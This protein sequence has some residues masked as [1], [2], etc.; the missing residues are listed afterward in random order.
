[1]RCYTINREADSGQDRG[2]LRGRKVGEKSNAS[3]G[4]RRRE[5]DKGKVG[6]GRTERWGK[7]RGG[8]VSGRAAVMTQNSRMLQ[9]CLSSNFGV[10]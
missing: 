4:T 3:E 8:E 9:F 2:S 5:E 10:F 7:G 1:M 6:G